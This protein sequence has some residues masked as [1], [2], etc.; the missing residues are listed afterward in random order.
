[1]ID[2]PK[3]PLR[4]EDHVAAFAVGVVDQ[5]VK[6]HHGRQALEIC[7]AE[8]EVVVIWVVG[9]EELQRARAMGAVIAEDGWGDQLPAQG[10]AD[11][12][13]GGFAV[14]QGVVGEIPQ[15]LLALLRFIHRPESDLQMFDLC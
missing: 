9:D 12:E 4:P 14:C 15:G 1:M 10:L 6:K 8:V 2:Q 7:V 5:Q 3:L 11:Q 13:G